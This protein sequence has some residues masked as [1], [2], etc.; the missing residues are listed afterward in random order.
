M[1]LP[2]MLRP[3]VIIR[4]KAM[5]MGFLGPSRFWKVVGLV[6]F[7]K[8]SITKFF[9]NHS[10]RLGYDARVYTELGN[11]SYHVAG[12]YRF[13]Q[14]FTNGGS[15]LPSAPIGQDLASLLLGLPAS[16]SQIEIAPTRD[17]RSLYQG[18]FVQDDWKVTERL[19]VNLGLR[20]EHEGAPTEAGNANVR[21]FDPT[22][23]LAVTAAGRPASRLR[24]M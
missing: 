2:R 21:G 17:N 8:R 24:I 15:G 10:V 20:Y 19:T 13:N 11:P 12:A 22:A 9:G 6:V 16:N 3:S 18:V 14:G 7:G 1:A 23:T 5:Y 4:R